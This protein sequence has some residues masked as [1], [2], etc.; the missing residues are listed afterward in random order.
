MGAWI[1]ITFSRGLLAPVTVAPVW[2]RGLK[3]VRAGTD[4][5][6]E[7]V[8]PV[9]GRGLK[10]DKTGLS[11]VAIDVAPVWGRGLKSARLRTGSRLTKSPP[12]GGVD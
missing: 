2:G 12:Y 4:Q 3:L 1:E 7:I 9:W 8:A 11:G 5:A 10:L 6:A